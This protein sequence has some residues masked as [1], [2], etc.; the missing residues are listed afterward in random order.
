MRIHAMTATRYRVIQV[1]A[2][3]LA[4]GLTV[5]GVSQ[6]GAIWTD[7]HQRLEAAR[8]HALQAAAFAQ[9][10]IDATLMRVGRSVDRIASTLAAQRFPDQAA[11]EATLRQLL[12]SDR[13]YV[14]A[15]IAFAPYTYDRRLRLSGL[16]LRVGSDG[17]ARVDL[18]A[19]QDYTKPDA[20]WYHVPMRGEPA[21]LPPS[22]DKAA[23]QMQVVHAAPIKPRSKAAT[24]VVYARYNVDSF[25]AVLN[26]FDFGKNGY[27][28]LVSRKGTFL[29]HPN[30]ALIG[31]SAARPVNALHT[32]AA[33]RELPGFSGEDFRPARSA[34]SQ[35]DRGTI[36]ISRDLD[37][38]GWKLGLVLA[39]R[40][41]LADPRSRRRAMIHLMLTLGLAALAVAVALS[42]VAPTLS[43]GLWMISWA[44]AAICVV[45][46][47][48][49]IRTS[50]ATAGLETGQHQLVTQPYTLAQFRA[51]Q[52]RRTLDQ[53]A[54]IPL[55]IPTGIYVQSIN[56][57]APT[58]LRVTG[59][60][61]QRYTR[62][63]HDDV[64]RG[65]LMPESASLEMEKSYSGTA[66]DATVVGW[67]F[68]ATIS[69]ALEYTGY[70]FG[71]ER[72]RIQLWHRQFYRNV[73]LVP[74]L[75]A[76]KNTMPAARPGLGNELTIPGWSIERS[77]FSYRN[78]SYSTTFGL[79]GYGGLTDFPEMYFNISLK[80]Q[81]VGPLVSNILPLTVVL[82]LLFAILVLGSTRGQQKRAGIAIDAVAAGGG[83]F[84]LVIFSHIGLREDLAAREIFYLEYY[85]FIVYVAI[86][87]VTINYLLFTNTRLRLVEY[88]NNFVAKCLYWPLTQLS[89]LIL[90]L[91]Q[92]Y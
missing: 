69:E 38:A 40:D 54:Q 77:M 34:D 27:A 91:V 41:F 87:A 29:V 71:R 52:T 61:W 84:L 6:W 55:F 60:I 20:R 24:G 18:D 68:K 32:D 85:Y 11:L 39:E 28:Y 19:A 42:T 92:F 33:A 73:I 67:N 65:F 66:G 90:T 22:Y 74:D 45:L 4:A 48:L 1:V 5:A 9:A 79:S 12:Y 89:I 72:V 88:R 78:Q 26:E 25:E 64:Q 63:I 2:P 83:L 16:A 56:F 36:R 37:T 43:Q 58:D 51:A 7:R 59:Y 21:W 53:L 44:F 3:V 76:Y 10:R 31:K 80:K 8:T 30:R 35:H 62:G 14:E 17:I 15:G 47:W 23:R 46:Y 13:G 82:I 81:I 75:Q 70:P 49:V 57:T 50:I 86:L